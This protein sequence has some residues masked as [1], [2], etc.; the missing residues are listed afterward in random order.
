MSMFGRCFQ[1]GKESK[2]WATVGTLHDHVRC[3]S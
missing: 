2:N 3:H 1:W